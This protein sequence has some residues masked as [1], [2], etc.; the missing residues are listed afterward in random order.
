MQ[1]LA[2]L[3]VT[4]LLAMPLAAQETYNVK[5]ISAGTD[6]FKVIMME[7]GA[8]DIIDGSSVELV[9]TLL[10][11]HNFDLNTDFFV[12]GGELSYSRVPLGPSDVQ[13][14]FDV[15]VNYELKLACMKGSLG[16]LTIQLWHNNVLQEEYVNDETGDWCFQNWNFFPGLGAP[17]EGTTVPNTEA[18]SQNY[19]NPFNPSTTIVYDL[20]RAGDVQ[21]NIYNSAGQMVATLIDDYYQPGNYSVLWDG[22]NA[23]GTAVAS[24]T[25]F[26]ELVVDNQHQAKQMILLK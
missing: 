5:V 11:I 17:G 15:H 2:V 14:D 13:V 4:C 9:S 18:L 23:A 26:Y 8:E 7:I 3:S 16:T 22:K 6:W 19:P 24:G 20:Q 25:Y 1:V 12:N 10:P 21:V